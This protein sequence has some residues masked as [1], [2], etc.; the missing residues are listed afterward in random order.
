[1]SNLVSVKHT[2]VHETAIVEPGVQLGP[3]TRIWA[4]AHI[5][6]GAQLGADCNICD[7]VFIESDVILGDRVTVKSGV[8]VWDGITLEDDVF[9]G[10]NATFTNDPFPRSKQHPEAFTRTLVRR[11]A[12]VGANATI[13]AGIAVGAMAMVGA[14]A[15][16]TRDVPPNAIVAGNPARI[17][18]YVA[19]QANKRLRAA[20]SSHEAGV[21]TVPGARLIRLALV[22]DLRGSLTFAEVGEHLPFDPKRYFVMLGVPTTEVR[23][24]HAHKEQHR[25]FVCLQGTVSVVLDDGRSRDEVVLNQPNVG[26]HIPPMIWATHYKYSRDAILMVFASD[27]Y[28]A[29]DYVRDYDLYLEVVAEQEAAQDE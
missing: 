21:L 22:E 9:I 25:F 15:V 12:S 6:G 24:E 5:L 28:D 13:L 19:S 27:V 10:P 23:G 16:V 2:F 3:G 29:D 4:F 18:G 14:G 1:V 8:Q 17:Q 20:T 26:L 7:H 11:G